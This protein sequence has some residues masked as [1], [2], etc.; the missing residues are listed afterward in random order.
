MNHGKTLNDN[1]AFQNWMN[2]FLTNGW[3]TFRYLLDEPGTSSSSW[4][5]INTTAAT[6]RTFSH[7]IPELVTTQWYEANANSGL[8]SIDIMAALLPCSSYPSGK[9]CNGDEAAGPYEM[10]NDSNLTT[11][12]AGKCCAGTGP[13]RQLWRYTDCEPDCG[14]GLVMNYP[15]YF[16][17]QLPVA[18]RAM[19]WTT[20]LADL[21]TAG[22]TITGELYFLVDNCFYNGGGCSTTPDPWNSVKSTGDNGDGTLVYYGT[23]STHCPGCPGRATAVNVSIP[24]FLPTVRLFLYREGIEDYEYMH[25]LAATYGQASNVKS[26]INTWMTNSYTFN[27]ES[28]RASGVFTGDMTDAYMTL[29]SDVHQITYPSGG[30]TVPAA[31]KAF[32]MLAAK[33]PPGMRPERK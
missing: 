29:G 30:S 4:S 27:I 8:N 13:A 6:D 2:T 3:S 21:G 33:N 15:S 23:N 31:S 20:E 1:T 5:T 32:F 22:F 24:I 18:N 25:L 11:W 7:I 16:V 28:T 26:I 14:G 19:E 9:Q 17:D 10:G 12:L